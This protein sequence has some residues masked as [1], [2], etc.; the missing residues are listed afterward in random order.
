MKHY[1][2]SHKY[3]ASFCTSGENRWNYRR[4]PWSSTWQLS[5]LRRLYGH[6]VSLS[7]GFQGL[8][9]PEWQTN[10]WIFLRVLLANSCFSGLIFLASQKHYERPCELWLFFLS[11][12]KLDSSVLLVA[13]TARG[14]VVLVSYSKQ[15][16]TV[17]NI[18]PNN[19]HLISVLINN[20]L[21]VCI[22]TY[23]I[24]LSLH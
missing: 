24:V 7:V 12:I 4:E 18:W 9:L 5:E 23:Y 22:Q 14:K 10:S 20:S 8:W 11:Q 1:S 15:E 3:F 17:C 13:K 16:E 19:T 6:T 21:F 2:A